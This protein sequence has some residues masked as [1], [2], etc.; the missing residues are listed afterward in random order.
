MICAIDKC[1]D[2]TVLYMYH[3]CSP[4]SYGWQLPGQARPFKIF[5]PTIMQAHT[6]LLCAA[7]VVM[8]LLI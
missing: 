1:A 7:L 2:A 8:R 4:A 3:L 5:R 6:V